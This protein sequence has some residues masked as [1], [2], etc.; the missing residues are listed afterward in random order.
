MVST[1]SSQ[2]NII[3]QA[4]RTIS[5]GADVKKYISAVTNGDIDKVLHPDDSL[6]R[7][8]GV[9]P[10]VKDKPYLLFFDLV[11]CAKSGQGPCYTPQVRTLLIYI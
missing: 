8:C 4:T 9:H 3:V 6:K 2:F 10:D 11:K 5:A 7:K 1:T